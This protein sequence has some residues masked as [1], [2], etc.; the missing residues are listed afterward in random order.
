M[1]QIGGHDADRSA[2][3]A[4]V[5]AII[6]EIADAGFECALA[7]MTVQTR[8]LVWMLKLTRGADEAAI[9]FDNTIA[10]AQVAGDD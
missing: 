10:A 9:L 2:R 3:A 4:A 5:D 8:N 6:D 1:E 7:V